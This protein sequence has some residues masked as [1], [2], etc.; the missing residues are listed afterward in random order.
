MPEKVAAQTSYSASGLCAIFGGL[1]A[2]EIALYGGL[3]FAGLTWLT[4]FYFHWKKDRRDA[5]VAM[6]QMEKLHGNG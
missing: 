4:N 6:L 3:V 2:N 1:T 5:M